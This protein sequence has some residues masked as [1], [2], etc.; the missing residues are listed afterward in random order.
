MEFVQP[1]RGLQSPNG[2]GPARRP[3]MNMLHLLRHAKSSA[4]EDVEDHERPLSRRGHDAARRVGKHLPAMTGT[5]DLVLCSSALRTRETLD[6]VLAEFS[7][8]LHDASD[9]EI[10]PL[11][12]ESLIQL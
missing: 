6:L 7:F 2:H 1:C 8:R 10:Y 5:L 9:D 12:L 3:I 4:K 11:T